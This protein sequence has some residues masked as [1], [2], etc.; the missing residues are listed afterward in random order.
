MS[1]PA[2]C[3]T[4]EL[5]CALWRLGRDHDAPPEWH[6]PVRHKVVYDPFV[7]RFMSADPI[8][9]EPEHSQSFNRYTY[10]WNNPTNM[11]DPT[12][13]M[14]MDS[15]TT[16]GSGES[17][18]DKACEDEKNAE[19]PSK[20]NEKKD[21]NS[22]DNTNTSPKPAASELPQVT[23]TRPQL[24]P[25]LLG[26]RF[27]SP[28]KGSDYKSSS[29]FE[30]AAKGFF[31]GAWSVAIGTSNSARFL[32]RASG[33][34]GQ[35]EKERSKQEAAELEKF[36]KRY[37][38]D[39]EFRELVNQEIRALARDFT[40]D[41]PVSVKWYMAGR[42]GFG[43]ATGFGPAASLGDFLRALENGHNQVDSLIKGGVFG[44]SDSGTKK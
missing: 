9:Q 37:N 35:R 28:V 34:L 20:D 19:K 12:G 14:A 42:V 44:Q 40:F 43:M 2:Y 41:D 15:N 31:K 32:A 22:S 6:D 38:D 10:V 11:T 8:I 26:S 25:Y 30:R 29:S 27:N 18:C 33:V 24:D 7:A 17:G 1:S 39:E 5:D 16:Q 4:S 3:P 13:F 21:S 36:V 23:I